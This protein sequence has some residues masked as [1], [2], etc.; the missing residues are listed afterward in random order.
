MEIWSVAL[1]TFGFLFAGFVKGATGLG[2]SSTCLPF[3]VLALGVEAALP[4]VLVPSLTSNTLV[5][6]EAGHFRQTANR[7]F[8]MYVAAGLGIVIGLFLLVQIDKMIAGAILGIVLIVYA[9]Y[10][11][12]KPDLALNP[13]IEAPLRFPVGLGTGIINGMTGCQLIPVLPYLMAL[14]LDPNRFIQAINISF[15][16]SS[17]LMAIGLTHIGYM[18]W[19]IAALSALALLPMYIGVRSGNSLRQR[20]SVATFRTCVLVLLIFLGAVLVARLFA[21]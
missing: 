4:M 6:L 17:L 16:L 19:R 18:T 15:T 8:S 1:A 9:L 12:A 10:S 7:F 13:K 21:D 5:M 2:F 3:L 20:M 11:L 14:R